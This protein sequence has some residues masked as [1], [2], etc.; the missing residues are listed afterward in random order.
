MPFD[1]TDA[2]I[3]QVLGMLGIKP[4]TRWIF[5]DAGLDWRASMTDQQWDQWMASCSHFP[6]MPANR[7]QILQ[8]LRSHR[9]AKEVD[10][11]IL[12]REV[13]KI[14]NWR[15]LEEYGVSDMTYST[16][17]VRWQVRNKSIMA[18]KAID[19][20]HGKPQSHLSYHKYEDAFAYPLR[21]H[22][23]RAMKAAWEKLHLQTA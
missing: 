8:T 19:V 23:S 15:A 22:Q 18:Y 7:E 12:A 14:Y 16:D 4:V 10:H 1:Y 17:V 13:T 2:A 9:Y 20:K 6:G 3:R 11:L 21:P 5:T